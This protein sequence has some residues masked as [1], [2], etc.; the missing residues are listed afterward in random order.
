MPVIGKKKPQ[1]NPE[2]ILSKVSEY[3]IYRYYLGHDIS[4]GEAMLSPFRKE[5]NPS[6]TIRQNS[7]NEW[8]HK[9]WADSEK[10]G[11]CIDFVM[12]L[13]NE[14]FYASLRRIDSDFGLGI[15]GRNQIE[16]E[17]GLRPP[18]PDPQK[19]I[20]AFIQVVAG[21]FTPA[22]IRYWSEYGI[23]LD[24]LRENGVYNTKKLFLNRQL[25]LVDEEGLTFGYLYGERWKIYRPLEGKDSKWM[26]N[27]PGS[28]IS[29]KE[30]MIKGGRIALITK[31]KKDE[32]VLTKLIPTTCSCQNESNRAIPMEFLNLLK[33]NFEEVWL[34]FDADATGMK[35]AK[36]YEQFGVKL[37]FCPSGYQKP[38]GSII[39]D[40]ADLARYHGYETVINYFKSKNL[41]Q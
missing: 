4:P 14:D 31:S 33:D 40:F 29:G 37:I 25:Y 39:K 3:D 28:K 7:M 30:K 9:D 18:T 22:G 26:T 15:I 11:G 32:M 36:H 12:Q 19:K 8:R 41:I 17:A 13:H 2:Y 23:T 38:D 5:N 6:L 20:P 1:L 21:Q 35:E 16:R 24:E 34:N 10:C 27:V